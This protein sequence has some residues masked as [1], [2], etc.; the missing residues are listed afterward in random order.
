MAQ[1]FPHAQ[2]R[3]IPLDILRPGPL[4]FISK[5]RLWVLI[6]LRPQLGMNPRAI[7]AFSHPNI[8]CEQA[9]TAQ[10]PVRVRFA[11]EK[12][13]LIKEILI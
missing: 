1:E 5:I 2:V 13:S 6:W 10:L 8:P 7:K 12:S 3:S 4:T 9:S 11:Y